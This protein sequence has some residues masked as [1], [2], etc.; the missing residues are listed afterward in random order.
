MT[1]RKGPR[2]TTTRYER[3]K[4]RAGRTTCLATVLVSLLASCALNP[5]TGRPEP[6][7]TTV[8]GERR[9]GSE[10]TAKL[11]REVGFVE[12][13]PAAE[14]VRALGARLAEIAPRRDIAYEFHIVAMAEPNAFALP[15]GYVFV[16]RGLLA[17]ASSEAELANVLAHEVGHVA[18]R[19][20]VQRASVSA[21]FAIVTGLGAF[22]TG[23][24][25]P[26]LGRVVGGVGNLAGGLVVAPYS[27]SQEREADRLGQ[28]MAA[29]AGWDPRAMTTFLETL[30]R[31]E[32][33]NGGGVREGTFLDSHPTTPERVRET[34]RYAASLTAAEPRPIAAGR[35][36][37][38]E[39][40]DGLRV[41]PDPGAGVFVGGRFLQ[42][43]MDFL[44]AF[45][46]SW[47]TENAP[48]F[49]AARA[50][51][52]RALVVVQLVGE[53]DD[54]AA[55][56][57]AFARE[58]GVRLED[59]VER[60]EIG[61]LPAAHAVG[62]H[63][64][65]T[66][67]LTW[68]GHHDLVYQVTGAAPP[69]AFAAARGALAGVARSFRPLTAA[70]RAEIS[71]ARLRVVEARPDETLDA[72][73][74]RVGSPWSA[75][76]ALLAN[77]MAS[78]RDLHAG[79]LLKLPVPEPYVAPKAR[80]RPPPGDQSSFWKQKEGGSSSG[81]SSASRQADSRCCADLARKPKPASFMHCT[82]S[83]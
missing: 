45:P 78:A 33:A 62:R 74:A 27:R 60:A 31:D 34:A 15:G 10:E 75:E 79:D 19:H 20:A 68:I 35:R 2:T 6:V 41:G 50:R 16:S 43:T 52:G 58:S 64:S 21:P 49:V 39:R 70:D 13:V 63:R 46:P 7:L 17:L 83:C 47:E 8:A 56:A 24:V 67:D 4:A 5:V 23:L 65:A 30:E 72:L 38:L 73:L 51:D 36:A 53:G 11:G 37:F 59:G 28:Q 42:P 80:P 54:V 55:A 77:G 76:Q 32:V 40:L 44:V 69:E 66:L 12:D 22:A 61:G 82:S 26:T 71:D 14:Y 57:A 18:A 25:S 48:D 9:I 81:D 1:R 29:A 3:G